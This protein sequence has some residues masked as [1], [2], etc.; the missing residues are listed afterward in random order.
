MQ[1][2]L[3]RVVRISAPR[4]GTTPRT[5]A[6]DAL[7]GVDEH[8]ANAGR[9]WRRWGSTRRT[10][11]SQWLQ[12]LTGL[13]AAR[14]RAVTSGD[15]VPVE[16]LGTWFSVLQATTQSMQLTHRTADDHA[17]PSQVA[18]SMLTKFTFMPVPPISGS[19]A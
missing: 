4:T 16:P 10:R 8:D 15:P 1:N 2:A 18:R 7:V 3:V 13:M 17:E 11:L 12:R 6:A 14:E 19:V 5:L 9:G